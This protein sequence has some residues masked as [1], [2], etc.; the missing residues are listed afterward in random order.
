MRFRFLFSHQLNLV[1]QAAIVAT[2]ERDHNDVPFLGSLH[3]G[4]QLSARSH[5]R[6]AVPDGFAT[7]EL[8]AAAGEVRS[9]HMFGHYD[10]YVDDVFVAI[11]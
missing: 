6:M 4:R 5:S 7:S 9:K 8:L 11:K 10:L 2:G 3:G 1:A